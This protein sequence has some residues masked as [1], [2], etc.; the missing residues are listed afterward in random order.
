MKH[1]DNTQS[2]HRLAR[3]LAAHAVA[4][5]RAQF[6]VEEIT[7]RGI[8]ETQ[9]GVRTDWRQARKAYNDDRKL[10]I[11]G[12][13]L[14]YIGGLTNEGGSNE[15]S[16]LHRLEVKSDMNSSEL[17]REAAAEWGIVPSI[18]DTNPFA[19]SGYK[20]ASRLLKRDR[21]VIDKLEAFLLE[22]TTIDESTLN[23]WFHDNAPSYLLEELEQS[24]TY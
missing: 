24:D 19:H 9:S 23:R 4:A 13:T 3:H 7:L 5:L 22:R 12:F 6:R 11:R 16:E 8:S 10:L 17:L 15:L 2:E 20:L 14:A 1:D 18:Q 21:A